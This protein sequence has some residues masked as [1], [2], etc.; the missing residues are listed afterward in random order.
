VTLLLVG[1][2]TM[3]AE[4]YVG[5]PLRCGSIYD[6]THGWIAVDIDA[7]GWRCNDLVRVTVGDDVMLLPVRDSGPLSLYFIDT[8]AGLV[9][10]V[11]D[12]PF[13]VWPWGDRLSVE[14][15]IE[16]VTAGLRAIGERDRTEDRQEAAMGRFRDLAGQRFGRLLV[17]ERAGNKGRR[18]CWR[19]RCDCGAEVEVRSPSLTRGRTVS[20]GCYHYGLITKHG[21]WRTPVYRSWHSMMDR[22]NKPRHV[23]YMRYGGRGIKVCDRWLDFEQFYEDMG[24]RPAGQTLDRID[25]NGDYE[26]GNCQW[27]T[28]SQQG[29][30]QK[31]NRRLTYK[32]VTKCLA[33]WVETMGINYHT[34][35]HRLE[36]GWSVEDALTIPVRHGGGNRGISKT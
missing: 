24:H 25:N 18:V 9:P 15:S 14:G 34:L 11:G 13:H 7:T 28:P 16:N 21:M 5:Q 6:T 36:K 10:I 35:H 26:P 17:I 22:C 19:C 31:N 30:N 3:Y 1:M 2:L 20:C 8:P 32:G 27:A 23:A 4:P 12:L 33:G 29:R